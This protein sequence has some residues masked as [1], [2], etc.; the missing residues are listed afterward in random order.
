MPLGLTY[1]QPITLAA[2]RIV[3]AFMLWQLAAQRL[4]GLFGGE[5]A[6]I[7]S[8]AWF[9]GLV[10]FVGSL[11]VGVG[12][13][14]RLVAAVTAA[15]LLLLY[16][17]RYLPQGFPPIGAGLGE[18]L[19]LLFL[20]S[21]F[22]AFAGPGRFSVDGDLE[23]ERSDIER[24]LS[25]DGW[26]RYYPQALGACR[27]LVGLLFLLHGLPKLGLGGEA[28]AFMS[29]RWLAGVVESFGGAALTLGL[30]TVPVAFLASGQMAFAYFL[31]HAPR[32]F[33]P[34]ENG[35]DRAALFCFFF[36]FLVASGPGR[37]AL[38]GL[39]RKGSRAGQEVSAHAR[40][41]TLDE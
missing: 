13:L 22:M 31:S 36:L 3:M 2:L 24:P 25:G 35:G 41:T 40:V 37:W 7:L 6:A 18:H 20:L 16:L 39:L 8:P 11:A 23:R 9:T 28:A 38:D 5:P 27:M 15:D 10:A 30:F 34:I 32:G 17:F 21:A 29:Q 4:F 33:F 1:F 19:A 12:F 26:R 14:T